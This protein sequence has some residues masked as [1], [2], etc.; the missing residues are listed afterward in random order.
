MS[1]PILIILNILF[2]LYWIFKLKRQFLL[3]VIVLLVGF[4]YVNR[5]YNLNE[6]KI[7]LTSDTKVMS[8]NVRMFNLYEWIDDKQVPSK[9]YAFI[10]E[11]DPDILAIQEFQPDPDIGFKFPYQYIQLSKKNKQFGHAIFSKFKIINTGTLNFEDSSN[12]AI[13]ADIVKGEDTVRVYNVHLESLKI[14]PQKDN[15]DQEIDEKLISRVKES[16]KKQ[17]DQALMIQN[18]IEEYQGKSII[19]GD[20]N[21]TPFSWPYHHLLKNK[22]DAFE[23]AGQGFGST[24]KT[25][26]PMRIDFI[27]SDKMLTVNNFKTFKVN[28]S[29][30]YPI[31]ARIQF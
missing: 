7:L 22:V 23:E 30:H 14:N 21:N 16:F 11:K 26:F 3:S 9:L 4:Q 13:F 25:F 15:F 5:F 20:F 2:A 1:I 10:N 29:D 27:L 24:Y 19:C 31:M 6:K 28:Y 17:A 12:N 8:Y 18:H